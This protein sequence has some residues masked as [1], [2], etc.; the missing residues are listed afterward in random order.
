MIADEVMCGS[1]RCGTWRALEHDGVAPDVMAVAKGLAGGYI[2]LSAAIYHER[3]R[4]PMFAAHGGLMTGHTFTG[5]TAACAAGVAV[6]KIIQRD[7]L[8]A[9]IQDNGLYLRSL[10]HETLGDR[11]YIGDIRGRGFFQGIEIVRDRD[12]KIPFSPDLKISGKLRERSFENGLICYP[13]SGNIDGREGDIIILSPPYIATR[14]E[15]DEIVDK[16][17]KSLTEIM[18]PISA[19]R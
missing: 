3:L 11:P 12:S 9:R 5:H 6:Q 18:D 2:P 4:A 16:L 7:R 17:Q 13:V 19:R 8:L 15:L 10:L 14:S 1:G